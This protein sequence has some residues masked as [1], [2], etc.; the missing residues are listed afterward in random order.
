MNA[1]PIVITM[2]IAC[3]MAAVPAAAGPDSLFDAPEEY[4]AHRNAPGP[5]G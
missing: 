5:G 3:I 2:L 1:R 4:L